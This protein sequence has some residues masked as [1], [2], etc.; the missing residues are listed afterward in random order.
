MSVEQVL[1]LCHRGAIEGCQ[2]ALFT[3]GEKP[4]LRYKA[5]RETFNELGFDSTID[6]VTEVAGAIETQ[7]VTW[8]DYL[9]SV[10]HCMVTHR[11]S[12]TI[13]P[14]LQKNYVKPRIIPL[15]RNSGLRS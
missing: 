9:A 11:Q 6:Y 8:A 7:F 5:A 3:L 10:I 14:T 15:T 1:E 2:E 13:A 12:A 4:E